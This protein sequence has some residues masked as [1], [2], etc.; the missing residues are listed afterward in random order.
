MLR[1]AYERRPSP[2]RWIARWAL[3]AAICL[4]L[5]ADAAA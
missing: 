1:F 3:A 4:S 5:A 2:V